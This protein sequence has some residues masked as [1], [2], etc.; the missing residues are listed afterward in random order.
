MS[1]KEE[2]LR[3]T[4]PPPLKPAPVWPAF[5]AFAVAMLFLG[6]VIALGYRM[7]AKDTTDWAEREAVK[8]GAAKFVVDDGGNVSFKWNDV[9]TPPAPAG[10]EKEGE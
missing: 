8:H 5:I 2:L 6:F 7:G 1:D 10:G 9:F 3:S 4:G